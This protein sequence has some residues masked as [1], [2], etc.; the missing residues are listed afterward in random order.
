MKNVQVTL[1]ITEF[2]SRIWIRLGL[3][4]DLKILRTDVKIKL[5]NKPD[6]VFIILHILL[7]RPQRLK[8]GIF[9]A[10]IKDYAKASKNTDQQAQ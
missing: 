4:F 10:L 5:I 7:F 3:A 6:N 2:S 9:R 8:Y 1:H